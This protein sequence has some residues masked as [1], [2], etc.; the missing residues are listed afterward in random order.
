MSGGTLYGRQRM[1]VSKVSHLECFVETGESQTYLD[2]YPYGDVDVTLRSF[3][4]I[5]PECL[6]CPPIIQ[7]HHADG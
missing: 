7:L 3:N 2:F 4:W 1:F 6:D 5:Q